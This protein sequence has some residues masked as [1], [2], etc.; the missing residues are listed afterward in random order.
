MTDPNKNKIL[1]ADDNEI[2]ATYL[3]IFLKKMGFNSIHVGNGLDALRLL[4]FERPDAVLLDIGMEPI[5]GISVLKHIKKEEKFSSLP[6][7]MV[8]GDDSTETIDKCRKNG[9]AAYLKK[10]VTIAELHKV[11]EGC[12]F[13]RR[14]Y[15]RASV[16]KEV[17]VIYNEKPYMLITDTLSEG[18]IY[19]KKKDPFPVGAEVQVILPFLDKGSFCLQG[20]VVYTKNPLEKDFDVLS[21]MGIQFKGHSEDAARKLKLYIEKIIAEGTRIV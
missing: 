4:K 15:Y 11:L 21:G 6:V 10:P 1:V 5:D 2:S 8:S 18:G 14:K 17:T 20:T 3:G 7:I 13:A 12:L 16:N 19:I 9:C